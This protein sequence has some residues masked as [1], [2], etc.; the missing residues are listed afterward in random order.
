[1]AD[2]AV[3]V[4]T[5]YLQSLDNLPDETKHIFDEIGVKEMALHDLGKQIQT[6]DQQI[7]SHVK[8]QGS[9]IPH[10][11]EESLYTAIRENYEKAIRIQ[12]EKVQLAERARAVLMRHIK[13]LDDKLV[14]LGPGFT[15]MELL[16]QAN[17][18]SLSSGSMYS[19][20]G[21][22]S[23]RQTPVQARHGAGRRQSSA[24]GRTTSQNGGFQYGMVDGVGTGRTQKASGAASKAPVKAGAAAYSGAVSEDEEE[25]EE[26]DN[27]KYCFCQQGSY[28]Q[29]VA[30]DNEDCEREWFHMECVGLRAPPEGTW[31]CEACREKIGN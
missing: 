29:M 24:F 16:S 18:L 21:V 5:D 23:A 27:E 6:A 9:H 8:S 15:P 1:M 25:Q 11:K 2:E 22:S 13:R 3:Y 31:Y 28:G 12:N 19:P 26:E 4:L 10:P 30:C 14:K 17:D 7:Q 20:A